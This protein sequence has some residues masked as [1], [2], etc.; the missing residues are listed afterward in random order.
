MDDAL[1]LFDSK[2]QLRRIRL[3]LA[4]AKEGKRM[5]H[6]CISKLPVSGL[7]KLVR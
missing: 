7:L 4:F 1:A 3:H 6:P 5:V 2:K